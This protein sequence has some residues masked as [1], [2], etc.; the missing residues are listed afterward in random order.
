MSWFQT[1]IPVFCYQK[2]NMSVNDI[3]ISLINSLRKIRLF[4]SLFQKASESI[5]SERNTRQT[6]A[7]HHMFKSDKIIVKIYIL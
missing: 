4:T 2:I 6:E 3:N 5:T 7:Y 1:A